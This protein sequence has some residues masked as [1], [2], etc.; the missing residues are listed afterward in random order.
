MYCNVLSIA[1]QESSSGVLQDLLEHPGHRRDPDR[2]LLRDLQHLSYIGGE[3][4]VGLA[5]GKPRRLPRLHQSCLLAD[6]L[7]LCSCYHGLHLLG[8]GQYGKTDGSR[9]IA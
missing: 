9:K 7:Q 1:D 2:C 4:Q 6:H 5:A 8:E 3:Q